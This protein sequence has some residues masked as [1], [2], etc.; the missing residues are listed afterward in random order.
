MIRFCWPGV[1]PCLSLTALIHVFSI[2]SA[3]T[4]YHC[5]DTTGNAIYSDAPCGA[6][7]KPVEVVPPSRSGA[8]STSGLPGGVL[9]AGSLARGP[10][11]KIRVDQCTV[12]MTQAWLKSPGASGGGIPQPIPTAD[13]VKR[14]ESIIPSDDGHAAQSP[15]PG[16]AKSAL[17][18]S[19]IVPGLKDAS[20]SDIVKEGSVAKLKEYLHAQNLS[21]NARSEADWSLL[22]HAA[23]QNQRD[24]AR[25]LIEQ[26][27]QVDASQQVG[28]KRG[29][30]PLHR[31]AEANAYEVA[32]LLI[33]AGAT[34]NYHG[35]LGVTPLIL[36]ASNGNTRT[37]QVLLDHGADISTP[38]GDR[39]TA[40]SEA[41]NNKHPEI[42]QLLLEH[43]PTPA[44]QTLSAIAMRGDVDSL[45]ILLRHDALAHDIDLTA[46]N[47]VL[48]FAILGPDHLAEREQMIELLIASGADVN[49]KVNNAPN[50]PLMLTASPDMADFLI[51]HGADPSAE[52]WYGTAADQLACNQEVKDPVGMLKVLLA[53]HAVITAV[54]K[55]GRSGLQ[56]AEASH[57]PE[58]MAFLESQHLLAATPSNTNDAEIMEL[59]KTQM[60]LLGNDNLVAYVDYLGRL[61]F[62]SV[63]AGQFVSS[64]SDPRWQRTFN[65]IKADLALD[66]APAFQEGNARTARDWDETL[67]GHLS[68]ADVHRLVVFYGSVFGRSYIGFQ[69]QLR[70]IQVASGPGAMRRLLA[71]ADLGVQSPGPPPRS[72]LERYRSLLDLSWN[73]LVMKKTLAVGP[74]AGRVGDLAAI[75]QVMDEATVSMYEADL[76]ALQARYASQLPQFAAFQGSPAAKALLDAYE[77]VATKS[78]SEGPNPLAAALSRSVATHSAAWRVM[79]QD[80]SAA[81]TVTQTGPITNVTAAGNLAATKPISCRSLDGLDN[82]HTP[83][84]LFPAVKDCVDHD[85]YAE[86]TDLAA[87]AGIYG[88]FDASRVTDESAGQA[89]KVLIMTT[90]GSVADSRRKLF[91]DA[92]RGV[93]SDPKAL[94]RLCERI[95]KIGFPSYYPRYMVMHGIRAFT[96]DPNKDALKPQFDPKATWVGLQTSYLNCP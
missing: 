60:A 31:A 93:N 70:D 40:L 25:Y 66:L 20:F 69:E 76:Q 57:R 84:D 11:R 74:L 28:P 34:V 30:T 77:V 2:S 24:I 4:I 29:M 91:E 14:C 71:G 80:T 61:Q 94:G 82:T 53:H 16:S 59:R 83:A 64:A 51:S 13:F 78:A 52:G 50:T 15:Q 55:S 7:A 6:D 17:A 87:L 22:D 79:L 92:V 90:L 42:V 56:C 18:T 12:L 45:R 73:S 8:D 32:S 10:A 96:G 5:K 54:P 1:R 21:V 72:A 62:A 26:G 3:A 67:A 33:A 37:V 86:A 46:K 9:G 27:A 41:T 95:R 38:T 19:V 43:V 65:Q 75:Q 85:R 88:A 36:A 81:F 47:T 89:T 48:R 39:K 68:P 35:P 44:L 49:N 58:V 63:N 23:Q